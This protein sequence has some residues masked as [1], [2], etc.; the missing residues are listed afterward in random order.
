ML[1]INIGEDMSLKAILKDN[2]FFL[3]NKLK[4]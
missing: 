4:F 1:Y 2:W 3:E